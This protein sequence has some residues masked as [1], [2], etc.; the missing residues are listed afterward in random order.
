ML[1][2][3]G[4]RDQSEDQTTSHGELHIAPHMVTGRGPMNHR[5]LHIAPHMVTGRGPTD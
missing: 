1:A 2:V 5:E 4:I 3:P